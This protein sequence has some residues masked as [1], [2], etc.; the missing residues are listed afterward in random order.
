MLAIIIAVTWLTA[1]AGLARAR[2]VHSAVVFT[3]SGDRT[4]LIGRQPSYQLTSLGAQQLYEAGA[5]F[6]QRYL[7]GSGSDSDSDSTDALIANLS[8]EILPHEALH[9]MTTSAQCNV[10]SAQA[11]LQ[12][13]YPPLTINSNS[14]SDDAPAT[15]QGTSV[16]ANGSYVDAPLGGYQYAQIRALSQYDPNTVFIA[17]D[18]NCPNHALRGALYFS[19]D[20]FVGLERG[21]RELYARVGEALMAD[22]SPSESWG[23]F[24]AYT[25]YDYARYQRAYSSAAEQLVS[26]EDVDQLRWLASSHQWAMNAGLVADEGDTGDVTA[27]GE[28]RSIAGRAFAAKVLGQLAL[29][30]DARGETDTLSLLFGDYEPF[31]AFAALAGLQDVAADFRGL[32]NFGSSMVFELFSNGDARGVDSDSGSGSEE[33]DSDSD[34]YPSRDDLWVR[35]LFRNGTQLDAAPS[36]SSDAS[37]PTLRAY[38]LFGRPVSETDMP[39]REFAA[40]MSRIMVGNV[41]SWCA[42]C[43]STSFFC[44]AYDS[45]GVAVSSSANDPGSYD[46]PGAGGGRRMTNQIAGVLGA[47]ATLAALLVLLVAAVGCGGVRVVRKR[48]GGKSEL[49]GFKGGRKLASDQDLVLPKGAAGTGTGIGAGAVVEAKGHERVGSWELRDGQGAERFGNLKDVE[50]PFGDP[51]KADERV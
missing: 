15:L 17:G 35:F 6:R 28:T 20:E 32:P 24:N 10:A 13:L 26:Q 33:S 44:A 19:T 50:G 41:S 39:W 49:G 51:V 7:T 2:I 9:I 5:I 31:L 25:I 21:S 43:S 36:A 45:T 48:G 37:S 14:S 23:Y 4:P 27:A 11:F 12:A 34:A 30:I 42:A 3:R 40:T 22:F 38:P 47:S 8:P 46:G 29:S 16:L 18:A 1:M